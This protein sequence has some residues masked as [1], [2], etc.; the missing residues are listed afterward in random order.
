MLTYTIRK[1]WT[2]ILNGLVLISWTLP[3]IVI[4]MGFMNFYSNKNILGLNLIEMGS[5]SIIIFAYSI[6]IM[7]IIIQALKSSLKNISYNYYE[8]SISLGIGKIKS[9][10]KVVLPRLIPTIFSLISICMVSLI[11]EFTISEN[12]YSYSNKP[13]S[14]V[15]RSEFSNST[16][17]QL[18]NVMV[19]SAMIF[20][21]SIILHKTITVIRIKFL[22]RYS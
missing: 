9:F 22:K 11:S 5:D 10:V 19:F 17:Y 2:K 7:N 18:A 4:A 8:S 13:I 15:Y 6:L 16:P 12:L 3:A 14:I 21:F 20:V 1:R